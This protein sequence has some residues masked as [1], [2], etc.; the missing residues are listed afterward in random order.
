MLR[1]GDAEFARTLDIQLGD[2][3]V[4]HVAQGRP[5]Q[6]SMLIQGQ[7][8]QQIPFKDG[9]LCMGN[10]TERVE[11]GFTDA[12]GDAAT[13]GDIAA[14]GNVSVGDTRHY[15]Y[16]YRD[17]NLSPCGFG[18]NFSQGLTVIWQ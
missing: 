3:T 17:P 5:A 7:Q 2:D 12:N 1:A 6:T 15:Q 14:L 8:Q 11:V 16:W 13:V 18:S 9:L 10:P 4:F